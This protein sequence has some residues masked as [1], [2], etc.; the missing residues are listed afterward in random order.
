[1]LKR[2]KEDMFEETSDLLIIFDNDLKTS[3][4]Q[5][6]THIDEESVEVTGIYKVPLQDCE[7]TNGIEGRNF[8]YRAPSQSVQEV[9]RLAQLEKSMVLQQI[10][11]YKPPREE[12]VDITKIGLMILIFVAF[13]IFG[14]SSCSG[15]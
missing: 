8:F 2:K 3:D 14:I 5:R 9:K 4:V 7:V 11:S 1:M 13:I 15:G 6:V 12:G 10:T